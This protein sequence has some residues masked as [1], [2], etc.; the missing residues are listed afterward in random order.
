MGAELAVQALT[1]AWELGEEGGSSGKAD[2]CW[3]GAGSHC[4][5]CFLIQCSASAA[6]VHR[7]LCG[8]GSLGGRDAHL[9]GLVLMC[10]L[11]YQ[12]PCCTVTLQALE[13]KPATAVRGVRLLTPPWDLQTGSVLIVGPC[14]P[15]AL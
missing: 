13:A 15:R 7:L 4:R 8:G 14:D 11:T 1:E 5:L 6:Q 10:Q 9:D 3:V 2:V 12:W